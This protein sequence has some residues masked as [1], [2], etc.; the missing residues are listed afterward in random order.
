MLDHTLPM[1]R[2]YLFNELDRFDLFV[3]TPQDDFSHL[4]NILPTTVLKV[5]PD[6]E[7]PEGKLLHGTNCRLKTGV[8]GYLQQLY[9]M[10]M[11]HM[12]LRDYQKSHGIQYDCIIRGRPDLFFLN[13]I[14]DPALLD[15][16][17]LYLPDFHQFDGVNDRF[18]MGSAAHMAIYLNKYD[19][20]HDYVD[21]WMARNPYALPV[22]AEMFTAGHLREAGIAVRQLPIRFNRVRP[23]GEL[24]DTV[25]AG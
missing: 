6:K 11:C 2:K 19:S 10:K 22:S 8:Q 7:L 12:L 1:L 5:M 18:A 4:A 24:E 15:L 16:D 20:F 17:F 25:P 14:P 21:R 23:H 13:S 9:G 3:Y